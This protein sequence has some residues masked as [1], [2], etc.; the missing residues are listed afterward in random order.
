MFFGRNDDFI[1]LFWD[2]LTFITQLFNIKSKEQNWGIV[3]FAHFF[4]NV[5]KTKQSEAKIIPPLGLM[6]FS[7]SLIKNT[8]KILWN[9]LSELIF[10]IKCKVWNWD[11][12]SSAQLGMPKWLYCEFDNVLTGLTLRSVFFYCFGQK[13]LKDRNFVKI[14]FPNLNNFDRFFFLPKIRHTNIENSLFSQSW[15]DKQ[16]IQSNFNFASHIFEHLG[17]GIR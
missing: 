15:V 7:I 11:R 10:L 14:E 6:V 1:N 17:I 5:T 13:K 16:F 8:V 4:E 12:G 2:L 3:I 9:N